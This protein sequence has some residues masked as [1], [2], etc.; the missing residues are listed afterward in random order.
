VSELGQR[1]HLARERAIEL[2]YEASMKDRS[3]GAI[4]GELVVSPDSYTV[5]ILTSTEEHRAR[6]EELITENSHEWTID[7]L[8]L[9]D[10]LI[11][12]LALGELLMGDAPPVAVV[13][14]ESVE[15]AKIFSTEGSASF[16]N[17]VLA[18]CVEHLT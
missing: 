12:S 13:L 4:V 6:I 14:D 8:A 11:M 5:S 17:G 2:A 15:F 7:R 9:M 1:R 10:R 3:F 18:A 16:V